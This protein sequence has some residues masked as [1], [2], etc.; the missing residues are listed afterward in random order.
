MNS[1]AALWRLAISAAIAFALFILLLSG[2]SEPLKAPTRAYTAKFTDISGLHEGADVRVRGVLAGRVVSMALERRRGQSVASVDFTLDKKYGVLSNTRIAVKFQTLTGARYLDVINPGEGYS[3]AS[4]VTTVPTT[5][6]E[7]SFDVTRLFNGL[8]PVFATLSPEELNAFAANTANFLEGDG[9]GLAPVL[10][11]IRKL[12]EFLADRQQVVATLMR[13]LSDVAEV[14]GGHATDLAHLI[15]MANE[16]VDE[17]LTVLDEFRKS[18]LY[19]PGFSSALVRLLSNAGLNN[20]IEIDTAM[21]TA[22]NN[23]DR[24]FDAF[25]LIPVMWEN[26][27]PPPAAGEPQPCARG[28]ARLPISMDVLLNGQRVVLCNR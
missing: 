26:I 27:P 2:V 4:L 13:N 18:Q 22:F 21:D 23:L 6:T 11:S 28:R 16:P 1:R 17:A 25:K 24:T 3:P 5:M 10:D 19:G 12:T 15:R 14:M 20:R 7:P 8:Q 9:N